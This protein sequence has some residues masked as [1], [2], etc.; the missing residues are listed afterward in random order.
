MTPRQPGPVL[1]TG[2]CVAVGGVGRGPRAA[3]AAQAGAAGGAPGAARPEL[4]PADVG[5]SLAA[6]RSVFEHRAVVHRR[7]PR[8]AAG[9]AGGGGGGR[10]CGGRGDRGR[11]R[12][13]GRAGW[14]SCS[15]VRGR[16]GRGWAGSWRRSARCSRPGWPSA[17]RRWR[18]YV[19][20]SLEE[21]LAGAP[22]AP[23]LER[24]EVVQPVLWAVM[25]SL[26]AVWQAAGVIPDAVVGHS[27]GEIAAATVAGILSLEDAARVVAVRSRA[28]SGLGRAGGM[29]SVV[30]AGGRRCGSCWPVGGPAVGGG[31][32]RPGGDGGVGG[33]GGAGRVRGGAV[34]AAGAALAGRRQSISSRT[35][36]GWTELRRAAGRSWPAIRPARGRSRLFSTVTGPVDGRAGAGRR[37][38]VRER[39]P[40]GPVRRG[41]PGAGRGRAPGV[42]RGVPAPGA[43]R[44][45][46]PRRLEDGRRGSRAG[47]DRDAATGRTPGPARL[48]S[49][50]ARVHVAGV[51]G[52]LGRGAGRRDG[53]WTCRPTRS[54]GSGTGREPSRPQRPGG[55]AGG[56]GAAGGRGAVLGGGR[57]RR[58]GRPGGRCWPVDGQAPFGE[59]LPALASWRRRERDR[60]VTGGWRYRVS[61][62]PVAEPGRPCWRGP[63]CWWS[64][65]GQ[66]GGGAGRGVRAGAGGAAAPGWW[67]SRSRAASWTGR[68]WRPG[69]A[70]RWRPDGCRGLAGVV[71]LLALDEGPLPGHPV[72][73]AG[74]AGTLV[75]VQALGDAGVDGAAVGADPRRGGGRAGRGAGQPGAGDG[76]GAGPG[77]RRWSTRTAGAAWSTCRRR[78]MSG[79]RRGCA[80]CWPGAGRTRSRSGP[81]GSWRRRLVR[82]AAARRAAPDVDAAR[83]RAGHRGDGG[84][85]RARGPVA[86]RARRAAGGAGQPV[87]SGR[88]RRR[89]AGRGAGRGRHRR[90]GGGLRRRRSGSRS[91]DCWPGSR[92]AGR[93]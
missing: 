25:V 18:R 16:S 31:G 17:A 44:G 76:V 11:R 45:D 28:L 90:R 68:C 77:R 24:A 9:R 53:G 37:V 21:V 32:E 14:C 85:R 93:R 61:W 42:H 88:A 34:G 59:V 7:G 54:S 82:A 30:D 46:R 75:L 52:G 3:L 56:D 72:V 83:D 57:G 40:D 15:P 27:Q 74:L 64:R 41:G 65:P 81:P 2:G 5:W 66:A 63:G 79:P 8:G 55:A 43:D 80:G 36:R 33:P 35:R 69:S 38:L 12:P 13:A 47:G 26:A 89:G 78:W 23:G 1:V 86:G 58:P 22:G 67:S 20:W 4:D 10:A 60:S 19:D 92:S 62:V 70:G 29:V 73:P 84:D 51:T 6:G 50:L 91:P 87:R 48:L 71:S 49:S 39:A